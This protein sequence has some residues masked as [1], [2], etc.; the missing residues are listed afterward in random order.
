MSNRV[1]GQI[2]IKVDGQMYD[3]KGAFTY[4]L[5]GTKKE[6]VVGH[7]RVHGYKELPQIPYM[8]GEITDRQS[9]SLAALQAITDAT[10]TIELANGKTFVLRNAWYAGESKGGTEEGNIDFRL[11]GMSGEEI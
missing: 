10:A 9:L 11:E 4:S 6:G 7:D 1:G 2:F 5:G 8:E 3:A